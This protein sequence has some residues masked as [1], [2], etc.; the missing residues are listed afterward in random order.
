MNIL[1]HEVELKL[2]PLLQKP[3]SLDFNDTI[4]ICT[5][6]LIFLNYQILM[7]FFPLDIC[8]HSKLMVF[9]KK[10]VI[11]NSKIDKVYHS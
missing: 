9:I 6:M 10:T 5:M 3:H 2:I 8:K 11:C 7:F 4:N 1:G